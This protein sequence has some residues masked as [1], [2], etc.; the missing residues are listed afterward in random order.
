MET[1]LTLNSIIYQN[2]SI[3]IKKKSRTIL[4]DGHRIN[5]TPEIMKRFFQTSLYALLCALM[6][7]CAVVRPGEVGMKQTIGKLKPKVYQ[8][9]AVGYNPFVTSVV[10]IPTRTEN[11]EVKLPLPSKDGLNVKSEISILYRISPDQAP[12]IIQQVGPNYEEVLILSVLRSAA[13]DVCSRFMAKDMYTDSRAEI[14]A[15]ILEHMMKIVGKRGFNIEQVLLKSIVLPPGLARA[16][17]EKLEA[18]QVAQRMEFELQRE[19]LEAKRKKIEAQGIRDAQ[20]IIEQGLSP[21]IIEWQSI[22]AFK[23]LAN[24]PNAKLI[25]SNGK[26]PFLIDSPPMDSSNHGPKSIEPG[27]STST[28][29]RTKN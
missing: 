26:T 12:A 1:F 24:S 20:Q 13:A 22:E 28:S 23:E 8:P 15:E 17:E 16:I 2:D 3:T 14:E 4:L 29:M 10:K 18:E 27:S 25:I 6:A 11:L 19:E 5:I 9:G 21:R 7:S